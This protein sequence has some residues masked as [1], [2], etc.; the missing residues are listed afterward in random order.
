MEMRFPKLVS[1]VRSPAKRQKRVY[2]DYLRNSS[3]QTVV[4]AYCLRPKANAPVST[5]LAWKEVKAGLNPLDFTIETVP[6]R[7][8]KVGDLLK[9]VLQKG[10]N[11]KKMPR[12][13]AGLFSGNK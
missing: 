12:I 4:S 5:P 7:I 1:L 2:I 13:I 8:E 10:I 9:P 6:E 11:L 3:H